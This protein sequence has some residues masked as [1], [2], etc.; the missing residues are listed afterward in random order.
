MD[1]GEEGRESLD[2]QQGSYRRRLSEREGKVR[3]PLSSGKRRRAAIIC[4]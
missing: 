4:R 1:F 2:K 3:D